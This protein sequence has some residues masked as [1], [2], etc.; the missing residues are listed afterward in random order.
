MNNLGKKDVE[1]I[2]NDVANRLHLDKDL[3]KDIWEDSRKKYFE[4]LGVQLGGDEILLL[5]N[6][7]CSHQGCIKQV[8]KPNYINSKLYCSVHYQQHLKQAKRQNS[9]ICS[10]IFMN[11]SPDITPHKHC[12]SKAS[13]GSLYCKRHQKKTCNQFQGIL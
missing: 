2:L 7:S 12:T 6:S 1:S 13:P 10:H 11:N 4:R 5:K 8:L 3:I 9:Q